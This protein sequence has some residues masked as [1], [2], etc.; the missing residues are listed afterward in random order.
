MSDIQTRTYHEQTLSL[1][2]RKRHSDTPFISNSVELR[3]DVFGAPDQAMAAID[4]SCA[5][6]CVAK[7]VTIAAINSNERMNT[8]IL[9]GSH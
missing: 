3:G 2:P 5:I 9:L 8:K 6:A 1:R 4:L 7:D